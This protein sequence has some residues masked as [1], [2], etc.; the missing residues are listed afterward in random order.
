MLKRGFAEARG[1]NNITI[2][3]DVSSEI[4][5][6]PLLFVRADLQSARNVYPKQKLF[7]RNLE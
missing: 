5:N 4:C 7:I 6:N 2:S 1:L 3:E